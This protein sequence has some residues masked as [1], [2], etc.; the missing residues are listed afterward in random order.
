MIFMVTRKF[1]ATVRRIPP[2]QNINRLSAASDSD[3]TEVCNNWQV[4]VTKMG[5]QPP[6]GALSDKMQVHLP[7]WH[8]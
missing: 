6:S 2:S 8:V 5:R 1:Y 4:R 7:G 3:P